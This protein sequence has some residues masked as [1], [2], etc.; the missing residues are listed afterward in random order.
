MFVKR[1]QP[2]FPGCFGYVTGN[3]LC[4]YLLVTG[5]EN[6]EL[7]MGAIGS[8]INPLMTGKWVAFS[9]GI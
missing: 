4:V 9:T 3:C 8:E 5:D 7:R 1:K 6:L 2:G